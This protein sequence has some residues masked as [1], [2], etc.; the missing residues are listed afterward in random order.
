MKAK[1][2]MNIS[3]FIAASPKECGGSECWLDGS[4]A[5]ASITFIYS[6]NVSLMQDMDRTTEEGQ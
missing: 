6:H 2:Y 4:V 1:F 3:C 5:L